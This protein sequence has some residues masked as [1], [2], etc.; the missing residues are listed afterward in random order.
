MDQIDQLL[1]N[2][3]QIGYRIRICGD[4][5]ILHEATTGQE[6]SLS[7]TDPSELLSF[8]SGVYKRTQDK[9][10]RS[11]R[12]KRSQITLKGWKLLKAHSAESSYSKKGNKGGTMGSGRPPCQGGLPGLGKHH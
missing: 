10:K 1:R 5:V 9:A 6:T 11:K 4:S 8:L 3:R 7:A 12:R 2:L